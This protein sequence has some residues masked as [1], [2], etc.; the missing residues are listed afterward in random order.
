MAWEQNVYIIFSFPQPPDCPQASLDPHQLFSW[1]SPMLVCAPGVCRGP[2]GIW[3]TAVES[4][5]TALPGSAALFLGQLSVVT[6][7]L[8]CFPI[9]WRRQSS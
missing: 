3:S 9:Q 7:C 5:C 8:S 2:A 1:C 4:A 6:D